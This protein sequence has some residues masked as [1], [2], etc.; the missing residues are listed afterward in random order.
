MPCSK[1][2]AFLALL[3]LHISTSDLQVFY[4]AAAHETGQEPAADLTP[5]HSMAEQPAVS[6]IPQATPA[7]VQQPPQQNEPPPAAQPSGALPAGRPAAAP[8]PAVAPPAAGPPAG[9]YKSHYRWGP[10]KE[11][12]GAE[13]HRSFMEWFTATPAD[14]KL[15]QA[16]LQ[17]E[18]QS[19]CEP[20]SISWSA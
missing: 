13:E 3:V 14:A 8:A 16:P 6:G 2:Y 11:C 17:R 7:A 19:L 5:R 15:R 18:W 20:K 9:E 4:I 1:P 10:C 12:T